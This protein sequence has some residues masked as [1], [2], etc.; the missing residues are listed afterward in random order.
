MQ[1]S[2]IGPAQLLAQAKRPLMFAHSAFVPVQ[3]VA[4]EPQVW[5]RLRLAS[6]PSAGFA[7]QSSKPGLHEATA[8]LPAAHRAWALGRLQG[9]VQVPQFWTSVCRFAQR[10]PQ[11]SGVAPA[12]LFAH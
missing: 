2:G 1:L 5:G 11:L 8:Q 4:Q 6:H 3:L 12:Q 9:L 7:L 10:V